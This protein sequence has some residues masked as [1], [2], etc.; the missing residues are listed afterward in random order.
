MT[1]HHQPGQPDQYPSQQYPAQGTPAYWGAQPPP[2]APAPAPRKS[3]PRRHWFLTAVIGLVALVV[4]GTIASAAGGGSSSTSSAPV[5]GAP[6]GGGAPGKATTWHPV[7]QMTTG[8]SKRSAPF[9][10]AGGRARIRYTVTGGDATLV[11]IYV[12]QQGK[13]LAKDGGIPEVTVS[14]DDLKGGKVSDST[15]LANGAGTYYLDVTNANGRVS[16]VVEELR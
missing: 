1:H 5:A 10:L 8:A 9:Q 4:L 14:P 12:V 7:T 6:A 15:E 3:W 11:A 2:P 16:L 13:S